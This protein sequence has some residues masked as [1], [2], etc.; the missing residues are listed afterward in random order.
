VT[1]SNRPAC[2]REERAPLGVPFTRAVT[3][4]PVAQVL[5]DAGASADAHLAA[6]RIDPDVLHRPET[7]VPLVFA[8]AFVER[9]ARAEGIAD[10]GLLAADRL[11]GL[12]DLG[13]FST[14][15][16]AAPSAVAYLREGARLV[17][18]LTS[19]ARYGLR[20]V[21]G[22]FRF[23]IAQPHAA[24]ERHA[25]AELYA[26]LATIRTLEA[27]AAAPWRPASLRVPPW[28]PIGAEG[29][30]RL[31]VDR[32]EHEG[33]DFSFPVEP[34]LLHRANPR[35]E[36]APAASS[37]LATHPAGLAAGVSAVL[38]AQHPFGD[39]TIALVAEAAES[40]VR[41]L[42]RRLRAENTSFARLRQAWRLRHATR[43]LR[44]TRE[45]VTD[46]AIA[47]GYTDAANFT[48]A[49]RGYAGCSP[50][51]FRAAN[52]TPRGDVALRAQMIAD[53]GEASRA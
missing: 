44:E 46:I 35:P 13:A 38:D 43:L 45:P 23:H 32:I 17:P 8:I 48:R 47:L 50:T 27:F 20:R 39:A 16:R 30:D 2:R 10:L 6:A 9:A 1:A 29:R 11:N 19:G 28:C 41:T 3:L 37:A 5:N 21:G 26:V 52:P 49:F 24:G 42:Q 4:G 36:R 18:H 34:W 14:R 12:T 31:A 40:S 22:A 15:L 25:H 51:V 7:P 53:V 33:A